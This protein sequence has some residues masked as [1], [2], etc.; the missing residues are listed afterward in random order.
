M[1]SLDPRATDGHATRCSASKL[2]RE[3][4]VL[5]R[6]LFRFSLSRP[7]RNSPKNLGLNLLACR[8]CY[9]RKV[10]VRATEALMAGHRWSGSCSEVMIS[11]SAVSPSSTSW[12]VG[13]RVDLSTGDTSQNISVV[14]PPKV[15]GRVCARA[16]APGGQVRNGGGAGDENLGT[17]C[18]QGFVVVSVPA[19]VG[20]K[21]GTG[22]PKLLLFSSTPS[23]SCLSCV[24][25]TIVYSQHRH[26]LI[27]T[28][29]SSSPPWAGT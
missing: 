6:N 17:V 4:T 27:N 5:E 21:N 22:S 12:F 28:G 18:M 14:S 2:N 15:L 10:C 9:A 7:R 16:E 3:I 19:L 29:A 26:H 11:S 24:W 23:V 20:S 13:H 1:F 25:H 8:F